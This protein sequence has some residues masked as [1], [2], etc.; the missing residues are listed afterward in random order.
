MKKIYILW[1]S[2]LVMALGCAKDV[3]SGKSTLNYYSLKDE[4]KFGNE[5]LVS[6]VQALKEKGKTVDTSTNAHELARLRNI[7]GRLSKVSHYPDF[8]YEVH[9]ADVDVVNAW[10]APGGKIMVYTGLWDSQKGLVQKGND[11]EIA[12][13]LGHEIAHAT[14]RHVTESLSR[15]M[16][17]AVA[18]SVAQS[19]I[20]AGSAQGADLFGE[21]FVQGMNVFVPSYSRKNE[22]EA[23]RLGL[24]YM[25][26]AGYDPRAALKLWQRAA[27]KRGDSTSIYASHPSDGT[28]AKQI[29]ELLPEALKEYEKARK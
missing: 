3:V 13:V 2:M 6:Q 23:D 19:A 16:T 4:P 22:L 12:A 21:V 11:A 7:V 5:V 25:A 1:M 14:A 9:L 8:P 10:C 27:S 15:N 17:I 18:G 28:R 20:G 24:M 26:K 29:E